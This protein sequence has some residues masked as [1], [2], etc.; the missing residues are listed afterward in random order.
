M[1]AAPEEL[2]PGGGARSA[3]K[4]HIIGAL[5]QRDRRQKASFQDVIE[6]Y[7]RLL[8]NTGLLWQLTGKIQTELKDPHICHTSR[9]PRISLLVP[10]SPESLHAMKEQ[11]QEQVTELQHTG[12]ELAY[13]IIELNKSL[14]A[15]DGKLEEQEV[16]V[17]D[18][19]EEVQHLEASRKCL[20]DLVDLQETENVELKV[21][22]DQVLKWKHQKEEKLR[23][24]V[25]KG[26]EI[27]QEMVKKKVQEAVNRNR[28]NERVKK[29]RISNEIK[30]ATEKTVNIDMER[31]EVMT[32]DL[33]ALSLDIPEPQ[34]SGRTLNRAFRSASATMLSSSK[35]VET[36]KEFF[37]FR[38]RRVNS[39]SSQSENVYPKAP[40]CVASS[41]PSKAIFV[42]E[43]HD[44]EVNGVKFS[45]SSKLVA[46]GGA[47]RVIKLWDVMGGRLHNIQNLEGCNSS[48]TSVEFS[49]S[50]T[51]ILAASSD[52]AAH[53]WSLDGNKSKDT[54][55]GHSDKVTAAKF[56]SVIHQAVTG[57][58]DRT[59]KEWDLH[60][61][62]CLRSIR[63]PSFCTDVVCSDYF[64]ISG[65]HDKKI[66][67]WDSRVTRCTQ[68]IPVQGK[69][70]SL[71]INPEQ[72]QLLS[73]S[74]DDTLKVIELRMNNV[75][76]VFSPDGNYAIAGSADGALFVWNVTTGRLE[77]SLQGMHSACVNAVAWSLSG[78]YVVSI[79]RK[80][81]VVLWS[82]F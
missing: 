79:D 32:L 75:R 24:A 40:L 73:C 17:S 64:I 72:T 1:A 62:A 76:Q 53:L 61:G 77:R 21:E 20:R 66:R 25:H 11:Y 67:F 15:K 52:K 10:S 56:K 19:D 70:T 71:N 30:K 36:F 8:E 82:S 54:L 50:G 4:R 18:L 69:V 74:R 5:K 49:P 81:M 58:M 60:K 3:W 51:Q 43:A 27:L 12:G 78:E 6:A 28:K 16:R 80:R 9:S 39:M 47:D 34:D 57:S 29:I 26:E 42:L 46:T 45:P 23:V 35:L 13:K 37:D 31:E 33:K 41:I 2:S 44:S 38:K 68:E 65:H 55:T 7:S 14:V 48:I 63:V 59:V 22:Y